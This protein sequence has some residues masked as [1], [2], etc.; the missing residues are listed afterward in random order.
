MAATARGNPSGMTVR[1]PPFDHR[2]DVGALWNQRRPEFAQIVNAGSLAMPYLEP[3]LMRVM[4]AVRGRITDPAIAADVD[5]YVRQE[6]AHF[7]AHRAFNDRLAAASPAV[8][9]IE[10]R[11]EAE[12]A[13]R[14]ETRSVEDGLAYAEGFES[15]ALAIGHMLIADRD[16]LFGGSESSVTSLI[17]WH[18]VEEIEHKNVTFDVFAHVDGSYW[19]RI[20][21]FAD[22]T[23]HILGLTRFGY[24]ALMVESGQWRSPRSRLALAVLL[25]RIAVRLVPR[26]L[27]VMVPG[28][29][30]RRVAD[31][32]WARAWAERFDTA[33]DAATRLDTS[34]LAEPVPAT[35]TS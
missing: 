29:S 27:R 3:Y 15:M 20:A 34:R 28:Y 26:L 35:L 13:A 8:A 31:P 4:R 5:L 30:P 6:A 24:R 11:L 18:F 10:G 23:W 25:A 22:A 16:S 7:Q 19:R 1:R 33:L 12:Y 14:W 21:G 32:A 9:A 17:L 2:P